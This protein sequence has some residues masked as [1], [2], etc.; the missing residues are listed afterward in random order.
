LMAISSPEM[1]LVPGRIC[2]NT[3]VNGE[4]KALRTEV[5]ITETATTN[6]TTDAVFI[7]DTEVLL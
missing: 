2:Q 4:R 7:T 6:L 5:D 3:F 1:M